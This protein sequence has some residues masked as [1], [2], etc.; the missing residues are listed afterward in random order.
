MPKVKDE[1]VTKGHETWGLFWKRRSCCCFASCWQKLPNDQVPVVAETQASSP[2]ITDLVIQS[3]IL[4][5]AGSETML[6]RATASLH[7]LRD[8]EGERCLLRQHEQTVAMLFS[9]RTAWH[10]VGTHSPCI[11]LGPSPTG[12]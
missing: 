5:L 6:P 12:P 3:Q 2:R 8:G 7:L 9:C 4:V 11:T 1:A 10:G